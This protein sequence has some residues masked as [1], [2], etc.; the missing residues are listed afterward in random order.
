MKRSERLRIVQT[1]AKQREDQA[2]QALAQ[3]RLQIATEQKRLD[4]LNQY[5][6]EYLTYLDTQAAAGIS[7]EQWRRTQGFADQLAKLAVQQN[8][9]LNSWRQ[10]EQQVLTMWRELHQRR[11]NIAQ[12]IDKIAIEE[13][14]AADKQEQKQL[15]ELITLR[16]SR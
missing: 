5:R 16:F 12:F 11:K 10:R 6:T 2:A 13:I 3:V 15:D 8:E 1:L 14:I 4:E 7:I 9:A